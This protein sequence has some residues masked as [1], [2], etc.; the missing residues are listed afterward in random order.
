MT[1]DTLI[2]GQEAPEAAQTLSVVIKD[3]GKQGRPEF[4]FSSP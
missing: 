2:S 4:P 1:K 3:T